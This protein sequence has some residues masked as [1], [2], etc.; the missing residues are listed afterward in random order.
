MDRLPPRAV[1][2]A[3]FVACAGLIAYA[4]YLQEQEGLDPCP[5]CILSRYIFIV[6]GVVCL[7]AALHGP[8]GVM[9]KVYGALAALLAL[10]GAGV[11]IRH[12]Y[13]QRFPPAIESCGSDLDFLVSNLPLSQ[14]LPKIFQGTGSCSLVDWRFLGLS[15][16]EWALVWYLLFAAAIVWVVFLRRP[17]GQGKGVTPWT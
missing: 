9:P 7:A 11:S 14:A 17:A 12:S 13:V 1:F 15:I 3:V 5:M 4:I 10:A 6:L 2:A 16:P 8:R